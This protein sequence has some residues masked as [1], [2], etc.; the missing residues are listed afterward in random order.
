MKEHRY[1]TNLQWTG[2]TGLGTNSYREYERAHRISVKGKYSIE[3]S[4]DTAFRGDKT[5]YNPEEMFL[6]SLSSCHM[7]WFLHLSSEAG[8]NIIEYSDNATG[9]MMESEDGNGKFT[10]VVLHPK[11]KVKE[12]WMLA[13][14]QELHDKAHHFC[15][16]SNSCNFPV[17][18]DWTAE[19]E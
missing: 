16:I 18:H 19:I 10:E 6:A 5:K 1:F 3:C 2:N 12:T 9:K 4:S 17:L 11:V 15:F 13:H 14:M 8:V 7:L